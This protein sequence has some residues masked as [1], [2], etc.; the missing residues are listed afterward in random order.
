GFTSN[1]IDHLR[2]DLFPEPQNQCDRVVARARDKRGRS[3]RN[4]D[5]RVIH[6]LSTG[7]DRG[8]GEV[9]LVVKLKRGV[10]RSVE[11]NAQ[12]DGVADG[13]I[14]AGNRLRGGSPASVQVEREIQRQR[15]GSPRQRCHHKT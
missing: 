5:A 1:R 12:A 15:G 9:R 7:K 2:G 13:P 8:S 3:P 14:K 10:E 6:Y 11:V 4:E